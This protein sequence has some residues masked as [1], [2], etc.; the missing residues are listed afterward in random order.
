MRCEPGQESARGRWTDRSSTQKARILAFLKENLGE[1]VCMAQIRRAVGVE[2][3]RGRVSDIYEDGYDID[4]ASTLPLCVDHNAQLYRLNHPEPG[5]PRLKA[6]GG[7]WSRDNWNGLTVRLH[8]DGHL[9]DHEQAAIRAAVRDAV[10]RTEGSTGG[11]YRELLEAV[12][13][14]RRLPG[15]W[16]HLVHALETLSKQAPKSP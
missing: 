13:V 4:G 12:H 7:V 6:H 8:L 16:D 5:T 14:L 1:A 2:N 3:V 9:P 11:V 15:G 10:L